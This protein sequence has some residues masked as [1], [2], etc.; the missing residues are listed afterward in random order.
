MTSHFD[1]PHLSKGLCVH[2]RNSWNGHNVLDVDN[3]QSMDLF[4]Q[5]IYHKIIC[6]IICDTVYN[7]NIY[8]WKLL[9]DIH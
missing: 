7:L 2:I 8:E 4:A 3:S 1:L 6:V 9:M 5:V